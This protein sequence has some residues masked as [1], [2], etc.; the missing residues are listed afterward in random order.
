M[1]NIKTKNT[2][3][4]SYVDI[5]K[6]KKAKVMTT[7]TN[8]N[9]SFVEHYLTVGLSESQYQVLETVSKIKAMSIQQYCHWALRQ[10]LEDDIELHFANET[11]DR[12]LDGLDNKE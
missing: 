12:M 6:N 3:S 11:K 2:D 7:T 4:D 1:T 8:N 10:V 5:K 9:P